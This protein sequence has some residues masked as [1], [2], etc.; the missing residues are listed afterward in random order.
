M[1]AAASAAI[2]AASKAR[3]QQLLA[4]ARRVVVLT[5]AGVSAESGVPTFRG[6]GGL[7]RKFDAT[8][9]ATPTAFASEPSLVWQFYAYRRAL[10]AR[11]R[12]N[13]AHVALAEF[14]RAWT[15]SSSA[16]AAGGD[17][18]SRSFTL[19]TQ[20][21]DGIHAAAGSRNILE[22]HGSIWRVCWA[23]PQG[24]RDTRRKPAWEDRR[25]PLVPA[26]A[27]AGDPDAETVDIPL[28]ELPHDEE[29]NRLLRPGVV[30][31]DEELDDEVQ[32]RID[33]A[34]AAADLLLI[35]GTS[36]VVYPAASYGPAFKRRGKPVIE[37]NPE[38]SLASNVAALSIAAR[39]GEVLP[40]LLGVEAEVAAAMQ[41]LQQQAEQ[42][43]QQAGE[44]R[45]Q[46]ELRHAK[47]GG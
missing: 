14:E 37:I 27:G 21:V 9:L 45:G 43:Q 20:N 26:L 17:S 28:E 31:F 19:I 47:A 30:F 34:L 24:K 33:E 10:V 44:G 32:E 42:Q 16:A 7:W 23:T 4:N 15:S 35:V 22:M 38:P 29:H 18:S 13:P 11:C 12:P 6:A 41:R 39:A 3:F 36:G 25:E 5:G 1:S 40:E 8:L 46:A 2:A